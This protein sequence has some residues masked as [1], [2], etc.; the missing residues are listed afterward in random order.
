MAKKDRNGILIVVSKYRFR[1][2]N[3]IH[4]RPTCVEIILMAYNKQTV[5]FVCFHYFYLQ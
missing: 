1:L 2:H 3:G 5:M 4:M